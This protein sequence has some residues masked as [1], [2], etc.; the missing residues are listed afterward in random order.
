MKNKLIIILSIAVVLVICIYFLVNYFSIE[1][2]DG[3][4]VSDED[5]KVTSDK[6]DIRGRLLSSSYYITDQRYNIEGD[7][8][9]IRIR[10]AGIIIPDAAKTGSIKI[11]IEMDTSSINK[12]YLI[13][14]DKTDTELILER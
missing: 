12:I 6:I 1:S 2:T 11:S 4:F 7:T 14:R 8:I 9:Y 5:I 13:G 3:L 10:T